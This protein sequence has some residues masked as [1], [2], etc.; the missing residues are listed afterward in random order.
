MPNLVLE[1][2]EGDY[3]NGPTA[4]KIKAQ[5][6]H[7]LMQA[8]KDNEDKLTELKH[9]ALEQLEDWQSVRSLGEPHHTA[10]HTTSRRPRT[11]P[12]PT[13]TKRKSRGTVA[14]ASVERSPVIGY[15]SQTERGTAYR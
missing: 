2:E 9:K 10:R 4:L 14:E 3:L 15:V 1:G 7:G 11:S 12:L 8:E 6:M 13:T 5:Q